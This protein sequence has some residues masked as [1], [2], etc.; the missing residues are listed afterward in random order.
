MNQVNARVES[1][2]GSVLPFGC[3]FIEFSEI[4][5]SHD[6]RRRSCRL[7]TTWLRTHVQLFLGFLVASMAL[8]DIP[9]ELKLNASTIQCRVSH[10]G[11]ATESFG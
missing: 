5:G 1:R 7:L 10:P 8:F 3:G 11:G 9:I 6:V 2:L 4:L